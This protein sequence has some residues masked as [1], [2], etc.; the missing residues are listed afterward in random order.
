MISVSCTCGR[1][2]KAEEHHAGKRTRCPVCGQLLIIGHSATGGPSGVNDNG[3]LPSWWFPTEPDPDMKPGPASPGRGGSNPDDIQTVI[4]PPK[5]SSHV[6]I[7]PS[8]PPGDRSRRA[9]LSLG[10]LAG[11]VLGVPIGLACF[12]WLR[13][14]GKEGPRS[15]DLPPG[16]KAPGQKQDPRHGAAKADADDGSA[17]GI[18]ASGPGPPLG[19]LV[20]A[21]FYPAGEGLK[22]WER[23]IEAAGK[24]PIVAV[25]NPGMARGNGWTPLTAC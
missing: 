11:V 3:E 24:V 8:S 2:F 21:Y 15:R 5:S 18:E 22:S 14:D 6:D 9:R 16:T 13:P 23:L 7:P 25:A 20:P 1:R 10:V 19:L 4:L 12:A 17:D